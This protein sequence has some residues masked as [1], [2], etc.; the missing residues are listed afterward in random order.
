MLQSK[1]LK[2]NSF[3]CIGL[4]LV[5]CQTT[6]SGTKNPPTSKGSQER[7]LKVTRSSDGLQDITWQIKQIHGKAARFYGQIPSLKLNSQLGVIQGHTGCNAIHGRY[8]LQAAQKRLALDAKA[9]HYSCDQALAQ[10]AE[11]AD[12]L[13]SVRR[14]Q[15]SGQQ[16]LLVDER[17]RSVIVAQKP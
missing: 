8:V 6:P 1:F 14:Y 5:A 7:P 3:L 17:G 2:I 10:E 12:A 13:A 4:F 11:L 15:L 16:L 9:G